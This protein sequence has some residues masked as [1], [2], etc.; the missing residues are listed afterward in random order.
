MIISFDL[1]GI[2][3][4]IIIPPL[5]LYLCKVAWE[6]GRTT[7]QLVN[8]KYLRKSF[9]KNNKV[10]R[11]NIRLSNEIANLIEKDDRL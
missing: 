1:T 4:L 11:E 5:V 3:C 8:N 9:E 7:R 2:F 6:L 10:Y